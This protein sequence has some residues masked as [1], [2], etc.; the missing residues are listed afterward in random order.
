[1]QVKN[2]KMDKIIPSNEIM[3]LFNKGFDP[4][5]IARLISSH[6]ELRR[7]LQQFKI[8]GTDGCKSCETGRVSMWKAYDKCLDCQVKL[9]DK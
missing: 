7:R 9:N 6:E 5:T 4:K 1:M 2:D 3:E 8:I